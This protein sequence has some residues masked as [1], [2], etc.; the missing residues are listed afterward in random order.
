MQFPAFYQAP[1]FVVLKRE[2]TIADIG[3][4]AE[5]SNISMII[6]KISRNG[7]EFAVIPVQDLQKLIDDAEMFA[8]VQAYDAAKGRLERGEDELIPFEIIER[9]INGESVP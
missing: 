4:G 8:D 2:P 6:E 7:K 5:R 3:N 1:G 9:R